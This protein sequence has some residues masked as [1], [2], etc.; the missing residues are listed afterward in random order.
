MNR[1]D[2]PTDDDLME[3]IQLNQ[4]LL[5]DVESHNRDCSHPDELIDLAGLWEMFADGRLEI[6]YENGAMKIDGCGYSR[7]ERRAVRKI[8]KPVVEA[9]RWLQKEEAAPGSWVES[10]DRGLTSDTGFVDFSCAKRKPK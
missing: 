10:T 4:L 5:Q 8:N 1:S 7:N 9:W 3:A 2:E 6:F